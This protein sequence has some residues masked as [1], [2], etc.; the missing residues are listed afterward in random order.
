MH[1]IKKCD[2]KSLKHLDTKILYYYIYKSKDICRVHTQ[3]FIWKEE[4]NNQKI[5]FI[6]IKN[7]IT[8][9][10]CGLD[11]KLGCFAKENFTLI[12]SYYKL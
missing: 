9:Y 7:G 3:L 11:L 10:V 1:K 5:T 4:T 6:D 8:E 12:I 2:E